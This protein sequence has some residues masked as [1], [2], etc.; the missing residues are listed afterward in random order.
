MQICLCYTGYIRCPAAPARDLFKDIR[1][2]VAPA[3]VQE[4]VA[5]T[6]LKFSQWSSE[7]YEECMAKQTA[8]FV[9]LHYLSH[10]FITLIYLE[11][12]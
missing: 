10:S 6:K 7:L 9:G 8:L 5:K 2:D 12:E 1:G 11:L 4:K 3:A